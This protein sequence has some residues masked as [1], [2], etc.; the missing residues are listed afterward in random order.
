MTFYVGDRAT[1]DAD[2]VKLL[3]EDTRHAAVDGWLAT[4]LPRLWPG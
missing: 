3:V 4:R 2:G 1:F